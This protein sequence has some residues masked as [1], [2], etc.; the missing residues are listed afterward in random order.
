MGVGAAAAAEVSDEGR[1][2]GARGGGQ[3]PQQLMRGGGE[4][5]ASRG[6]K[7]MGRQTQTT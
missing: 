6:D 3:E 1:E 5:N 2:T 7:M 4:K